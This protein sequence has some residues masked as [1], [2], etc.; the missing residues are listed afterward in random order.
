MVIL[1]RPGSST[2]LGRVTVNLLS[3]SRL[4]AV[5]PSTGLYADAGTD[6]QTKMLIP[7]PLSLASFD[8]NL[9]PLGFGDLGKV[10]SQYPILH[11]GLDP[12]PVDLI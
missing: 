4:L 1:F 10:Q 7:Y 6:S 12:L 8:G 2:P 5:S 3:N 9:A 11:D